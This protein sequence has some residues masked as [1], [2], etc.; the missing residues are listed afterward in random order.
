MAITYILLRAF[1][2]LNRRA[3]PRTT[4][5]DKA[6]LN[7]IN[8]PLLKLP[9]EIRNRIYEFVAADDGGPVSLQHLQSDDKDVKVRGYGTYAGLTR[10]CRQIREEFLPSEFRGRTLSYAVTNKALQ[11]SRRTPASRSTFLS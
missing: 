6:R 10:V 3:K 8:S 1:C 2:F 5:T 11:S 7:K 4:A 9:G